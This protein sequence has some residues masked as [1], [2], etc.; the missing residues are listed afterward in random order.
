MPRRKVLGDCIL[1]YRPHSVLDKHHDVHLAHSVQ[2]LSYGGFASHLA[3]PAGFAVHGLPRFVAQPACGQPF[4]SNLRTR[5]GDV[6]HSRTRT[7]RRGFDSLYHHTRGLGDVVDKT[8]G[9]AKAC[10]T[11]RNPQNSRVLPA[12]GL[13]HRGVSRPH[14]LAPSMSRRGRSGAHSLG[15]PR[16]HEVGPGQSIM[17]ICRREKSHHRAMGQMGVLVADPR[18]C[19]TSAATNQADVGAAG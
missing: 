4:N 3:L 7:N 17:K 19:G 2:A 16:R 10:L 12:V 9:K 15:V 5:H 11:V 8:E 18:I 6:V 1:S 13:H 14:A